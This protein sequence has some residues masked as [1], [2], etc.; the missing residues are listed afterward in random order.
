MCHEKT[1]PAKVTCE[2]LGVP[3]TADVADDRWNL[4]ADTAALA[5]RFVDAYLWFGRPWLHHVGSQPFVTKRAIKLA[6]TTPFR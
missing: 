3:P 6:N 5:A 4:P 1:T 2:T